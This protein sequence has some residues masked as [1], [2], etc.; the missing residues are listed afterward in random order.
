MW[1]SFNSKGC[2]T[3]KIL[4]HCE[5]FKLEIDLSLILEILGNLRMLNEILATT[6]I[7]VELSSAQFVIFRKIL[8]TTKSIRKLDRWKM[9]NC[10]LRHAQLPSTFAPLDFFSEI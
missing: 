9:D 2:S 7:F 3:Q 10:V 1:H 5:T 6:A 4:L 8:E